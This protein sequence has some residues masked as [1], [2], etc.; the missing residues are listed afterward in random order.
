MEPVNPDV[1][2]YGDQKN[3]VQLYYYLNIL[4]DSG[5]HGPDREVVDRY[6][7]ETHLQSGYECGDEDSIHFEL[8]VFGYLLDVELN[9]LT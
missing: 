4:L 5:F 2:G 9:Y 7:F 6:R 3:L 8:A 1:Q